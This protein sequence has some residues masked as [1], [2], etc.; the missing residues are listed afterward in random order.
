MK[1]CEASCQMF[2]CCSVDVGTAGGACLQCLTDVLPE[3]MAVPSWT[4]PTISGLR[5]PGS[6][7]LTGIKRPE[8]GPD[9]RPLHAGISQ[10]QVGDAAA[11]GS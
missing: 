8:Q 9:I 3:Y 4:L 10:A 7:M 1:G 5:T 2:V 11:A 6:G